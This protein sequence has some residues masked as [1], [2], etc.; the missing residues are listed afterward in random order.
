MERKGE[1]ERVPISSQD[2]ID[3]ANTSNF[4]DKAWVENQ[5]LKQAPTRLF[6]QFQLFCSYWAKKGHLIAHAGS[7]NKF[8]HRCHPKSA[9]TPKADIRPVSIRCLGQAEITEN[10]PIS[11]AA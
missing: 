2:T 8:A 10:A 7:I 1:S 4:A 11:A 5:L 6:D 9:L 3:G